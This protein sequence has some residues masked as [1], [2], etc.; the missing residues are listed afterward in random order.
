LNQIDLV[1]MVK[2]ISE[3]WLI[4]SILMITGGLLGLLISQVRPPIFESS[5]VFSVTIDYTQTGALTDIQED[6]AMRGVGSV[7][8]SDQ[9]VENTLSQISNEGNIVITQ[10]DFLENSFLDREEFRWT[11]RYRDDDPK[12]AEM[13]V[14]AWSKSADAII[15]GG[16]T[17]SL[18]S[19]VLQEELE[20]LKTDLF[21]FSN[22]NIPGNT[23]IRDFDSILDSI[24]LISARIQ[25]E[26]AASQGL[27]HPLTVSSINLGKSS[28]T[29]ELGQRNLLVLS[30]ALIGFFLNILEIIIEELKRSRSI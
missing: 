20:I 9:V 10:T 1:K 5:A 7:I 28:E 2:K 24:N 21:D 4:T 6:Q 17:H 25:A 14:N 13:V 26:K 16:L 30:G 3:R 19:I 29:A 11:L 23:G 22:G 27:F 15:Q 12:I 18:S 8:L